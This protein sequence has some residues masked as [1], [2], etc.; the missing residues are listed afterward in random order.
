VRGDRLLDPT[1]ESNPMDDRLIRGGRITTI[2][3]DAAS[4]VHGK[5]RLRGIARM[6]NQL[7]HARDRISVFKLLKRT[8]RFS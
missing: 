6:G 1:G 7:P 4:A 2:A 8:C 3:A 5:D